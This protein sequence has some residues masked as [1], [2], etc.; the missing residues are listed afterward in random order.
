MK[1]IEAILCYFSLKEGI[2]LSDKEQLKEFICLNKTYLNV[3]CWESKRLIHSGSQHWV[4]HDEEGED[5][6]KLSNIQQTLSN[7]DG[8][9][10]K[11]RMECQEVKNL[12]PTHQKGYPEEKVPDRY[13]DAVS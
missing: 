4:T 10:S 3:V 5:H 12:D 13:I 1:S 11:E 9:G 7:D 2:N 6:N 8:P